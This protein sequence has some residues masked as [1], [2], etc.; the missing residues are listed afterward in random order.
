LIFI[1]IINKYSNKDFNENNL[2]IFN[3]VS[4]KPLVPLEHYKETIESADV[5]IIA[6]NFDQKSIA[7]TRLS[8]ANKLPE[9]LAAGNTLFTYGPL[10]IAT[11]QHIHDKGLGP[12]VVNQDVLELKQQLKKIIYD[13]NLR[14]QCVANGISYAKSNYSL[15]QM[16]YKI[17]A[18]FGLA[19][20]KSL[21]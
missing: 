11:V 7:Y 20:S 3:S 15:R 10:D 13:E 18:F 2:G 12:V 5:S 21:A 4:V 6:Y 9:I 1:F 17:N 19:I 14:S 8:M 16:R